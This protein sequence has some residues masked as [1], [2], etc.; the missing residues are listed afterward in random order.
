MYNVYMKNILE[1]F[2]TRY[3]IDPNTGCWNWNGKAKVSIGYGRINYNG[4]SY[5]AHRFSMMIHG[6][7]PTGYFVCHH[8][9]NPKCVNPEH[10]YLGDAKTNAADAI[11]RGRWRTQYGDSNRSSKLTSADVILIRDNPD[12]L[13]VKQ[14]AKLFGVTKY[15][16]QDILHNRTWKVI[17]T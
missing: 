4:K 9:D 16:I 3:D 2:C 1:T 6:K 10:L 17:R 15:T 11:K 13:T 14:L 12:N 8:C 7:D 5:L